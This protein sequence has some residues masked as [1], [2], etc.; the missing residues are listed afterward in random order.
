MG[1]NKYIVSLAELWP[2]MQFLCTACPWGETCH[3]FQV[4]QQHLGLCRCPVFVRRRN[5]FHSV[6]VC[7]THPSSFRDHSL[8]HHH[9][10]KAVGGNHS[11]SSL[12][13][14]YACRIPCQKALVSIRAAGHAP[15]HHR[16]FCCG[17]LSAWHRHTQLLLIISVPSLPAATSQP[18]HGPRLF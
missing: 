5:W 10:W 2:K 17:F 9:P 8:P 13:Q 14:F 6:S 11:N 16:L 1:V 7:T 18:C 4:D 12:L 3:I 15:C